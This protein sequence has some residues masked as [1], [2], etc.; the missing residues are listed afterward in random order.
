MNKQSGMVGAEIRESN[1]S[2]KLSVRLLTVQPTFTLS[3]SQLHLIKKCREFLQINVFHLRFDMV[4]RLRFFPAM[5]IPSTRTRTDFA[6]DARSGTLRLVRSLVHFEWNLFELQLGMD[7]GKELD[8]LDQDAALP[9]QRTEDGEGA[10]WVS[11]PGS[12]GEGG[13]GKSGSGRT[14]K[15]NNME[16]IKMLS[17]WKKGYG[18]LREKS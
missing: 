2:Q 8:K 18:S 11:P 17:G 14:A 13:R 12:P 4:S 9:T 16:L 5:L 1:I 15:E 7:V 6:D 10:Q 3:T